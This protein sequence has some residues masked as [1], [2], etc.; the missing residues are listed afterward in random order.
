M[1]K[2]VMEWDELNLLRESVKTLVREYIQNPDQ[3]T[4]D[5]WCGYFE[6]VMDVV[7]AYGWKDAEEIVGIVPFRDD[8]NDK[9]VNLEIE[10]ETWKARVQR[11]VEEHSVSGILKIIDTE[12]QRDYN[13]GVLNAGQESGVPDLKKQW[14]T[15]LDDRV[16][17]THDYL[18]GTVVGINDLFYTYDDD[19]AYAP[20]GFGDPSN[21]INC[22]CWITLAK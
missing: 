22:R 17:D 14:N 5:K 6:Y 3:K 21:N 7:Y 18:E 1:K 15:M 8:L 4:V 12:A 9:A 2:K 11:Q 10:G 13:T 19:A 16:R 20:G